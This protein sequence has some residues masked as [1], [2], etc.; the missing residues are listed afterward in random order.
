MFLGKSLGM[1]AKPMHHGQYRPRR[2]IVE[3]IWLFWAVQGMNPLGGLLLV[4][5]R[6]LVV[7]SG[8][9]RSHFQFTT[10]SF[11][12]HRTAR[13]VL[14]DSPYASIVVAVGNISHSLLSSRSMYSQ[15]T[16][17]TVFL[18]S[19]ILLSRTMMKFGILLLSKPVTR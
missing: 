6:N 7:R 15:P 11:I 19:I 2:C 18:R 12:L 3:P 17:V 13:P 14:V 16:N 1:V 8:R 5:L 9:V 10:G 4:R